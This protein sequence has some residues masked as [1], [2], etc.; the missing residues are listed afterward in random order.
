MPPSFYVTLNFRAS[1]SNGVYV[2]FDSSTK[3]NSIKSL[4]GK[5][6]GP[7]GDGD[8]MIRAELDHLSSR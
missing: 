3:G 7:F 5:P 8:W 2:A 1:Y 4:P 6:P